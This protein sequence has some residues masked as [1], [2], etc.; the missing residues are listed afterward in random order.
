M[1]TARAKG[2]GNAPRIFMNGQ[3][4]AYSSRCRI[5]EAERYHHQ[6]LLVKRIAKLRSPRFTLCSSVST[7]VKD[8]RSDPKSRLL[9][10]FLRPL[11]Q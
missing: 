2:R 5:R 3:A 1:P 6:K 7:V 11:G 8:F 4:A 10:R 9:R